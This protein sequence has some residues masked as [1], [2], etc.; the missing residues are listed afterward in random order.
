[1]AGKYVG[2]WGGE[3]PVCSEKSS[4]AT[5]ILTSKCFRTTGLRYLGY[6]KYRIKYFNIRPFTNIRIF[7]RIITN[8]ARVQIKVL[9][10]HVRHIFFT[11]T[12]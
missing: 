2:G 1:M 9:Q 6:E 4:L 10:I 7:G 12:H 11:N 5:W 3:G 8:S